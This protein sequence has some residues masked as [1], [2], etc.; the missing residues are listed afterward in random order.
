MKCSAILV[1]VCSLWVTDG[2]CQSTLIFNEV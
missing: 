2:K 1:T